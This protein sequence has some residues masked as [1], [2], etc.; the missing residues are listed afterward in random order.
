LVQ[1]DTTTVMA[2]ASCAHY[3]RVRVGH[4]EAGLR[5]FDRA[6][7]IPE[8]MDHVVADHVSDLHFAPTLSARD[9]FLRE[10][11]P[12]A[13]I[14]VTGNTVVDALLYI[15]A[16]PRQPPTGDPLA[17][18]ASS[19]GGVAGEGGTSQHRRI[20][21]ARAHRRE[22]WGSPLQSICAA[23]RI[24]AERRDVQVVFPVHR[25]PNVWNSVHCELDGTPGVSL[26]PPLVYQ[27]MVYLM[28]VSSLVLTDS[29]GV[30]EEAPC[31]GLPVL[32]LRDVTERP[33]GVEAGIARLVGT[34]SQH[35]VA[36]ASHLLDDPFAYQG[37]ARVANPYGD[38]Q[39]ALRITQALWQYTASPRHS[40][41]VGDAGE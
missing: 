11:I 23:L 13:S 20:I 16:R 37:M 18:L 22:S 33:E 14:H 25:N 5:S 8:E 26:L 9:N 12:A 15:A 40:R 34:D 39:A 36:E 4:L 7:P 32:V 1:G 38:G 17:S 41:S 24:L 2:A 35:I 6:N 3:N 29:G 27:H 30:Q 19:M 31:L 21:I 28:K 10:G